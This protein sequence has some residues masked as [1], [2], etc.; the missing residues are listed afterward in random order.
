MPVTDGSATPKRRLAS[1]PLICQPKTV[2]KKEIVKE[3]VLRYTAIFEP[4]VEGGFTVTVPALPGCL[5]E[6]DT[7]EEAAANIREAV[8][9]YLEDASTEDRKAPCGRFSVRPP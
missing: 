2:A 1:V 4:Q 3:K 9:L 7:F 8:E 6:G 5:S